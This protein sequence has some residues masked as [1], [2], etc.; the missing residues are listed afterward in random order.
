MVPLAV[1]LRL[2][3]KRLTP[4]EADWLPDLVEGDVDV[5]A[6][7]LGAFLADGV[8]VG[9]AEVRPELAL[10]VSVNGNVENLMKKMFKL[11]YYDNANKCKA[12]VGQ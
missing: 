10:L 8:E 2:E 3:E 7:A 12:H 9:L 11:D 5:V 6:L 4:A 1:P